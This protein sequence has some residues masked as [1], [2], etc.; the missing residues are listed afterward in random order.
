M[1]RR[2]QRKLTLGPLRVRVGFR[3]VLHLIEQ[4]SVAVLRGQGQRGL[5][6]RGVDRTGAVQS[7]LRQ[8]TGFGEGVGITAETADKRKQGGTTFRYLGGFPGNRHP[9]LR[10][11]RLPGGADP[12]REL[13]LLLGRGEQARVD[14][15][16]LPEH[17]FG[18]LGARIGVGSFRKVE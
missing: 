1:K 10:Q 17:S 13:L 5:L 12:R 9:Q 14:R 6:Q 7:L 16:Q 2:Q 15:A 3:T 8:P 4:G 18:H 11:L